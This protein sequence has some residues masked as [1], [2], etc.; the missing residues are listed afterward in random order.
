MEEN[1]YPPTDFCWIKQHLFGIQVKNLTKPP[2]P[3]S[4]GIFDVYKDINDF[5]SRLGLD[6][7]W[8]HGNNPLSDSGLEDLFG[9]IKT[10]ELLKSPRI[11]SLGEFLL[12]IIHYLDNNNMP[13]IVLAQ[14]KNDCF[15]IY[16]KV[17]TYTI[18]I[19]GFIAKCTLLYAISI[20]IATNG[21]INYVITKKQIDAIVEEKKA[22]DKVLTR[23][24]LFGTS[25]KEKIKKV[26]KKVFSK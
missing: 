14:Q 23:L 24:T 26:N 7:L 4:F 6:I 19:S 9:V 5:D 1:T 15:I 25:G 16:D 2:S 3:T 10:K 21:I 13:R 22:N 12:V 8:S 18:S 11:D 20:I 17:N